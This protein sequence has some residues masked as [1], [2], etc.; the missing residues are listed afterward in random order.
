MVIFNQNHYNR[1]PFHHDVVLCVEFLWNEFGKKLDYHNVLFE[2]SLN[3]TQ[4]A[5]QNL[6]SFY[7][8]DMIPFTYDSLS[9]EKCDDIY[10]P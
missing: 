10:A 9:P 1:N 5:K 2:N 7:Y 6:S 8:S 4:Y 3:L